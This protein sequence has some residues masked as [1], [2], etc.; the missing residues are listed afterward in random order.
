MFQ[1]DLFPAGEQ[2]PSM[3]LAYAIGIYLPYRPSRI[4]FE[5]APAHPTPLVE[6]VAKPAPILQD[7]HR[8]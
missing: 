4:A 5:G 8:A 3:P 1:S 6:S 2:L 7:S